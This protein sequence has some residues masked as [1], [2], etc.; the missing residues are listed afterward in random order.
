MR[1]LKNRA[2]TCFLAVAVVIS[3]MP[4]LSGGFVHAE[5]V[6]KLDTT[7]ITID[8]GAYDAH[9]VR[10][11]DDSV[12]MIKDVKSSDESIAW[13]KVSA[14]PGSWVDIYADGVGTCTITVI[15]TNDQEIV[16]PVTVTTG[17][18]KSM[19]KGNADINYAYYGS[20]YIYV[21][22]FEGAVGTLKVG[23]DKYTIKKMGK[24]GVRKIKLKKVYKLNTKISCTLKWQGAKYTKKAKIISWADVYSAG[25]SKK[26]A[27]KLSVSFLY[28]HK[29]DIVKLKYGGKTYQKKIKKDYDE[30]NF[31]CTFTLKKKLKKNSTL[32]FVFYN[33]YKQKLGTSKVQ[34]KNW[35]YDAGDDEEGDD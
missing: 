6:L 17:W 29:G 4:F 11:T 5:D 16:I 30:K 27:N 35:W 14:E 26:K 23:S 21:S 33:K 7:S 34:L 19:L 13:A 2:I 24:S 8:S 20:K 1:I 28:L 18:A 25:S 22:A 31:K 9:Q 10:I 15:G 3:F 12:A 32:T